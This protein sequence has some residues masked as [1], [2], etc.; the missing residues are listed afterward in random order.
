MRRPARCGSQHPP[1]RLVACKTPRRK[2]AELGSCLCRAHSGSNPALVLIEAKA[3]VQEFTNGAAGQPAN[4]NSENRER[5]GRAISEARDAL[6]R[7]ANEIGISR[8]SW[9]QF[10]NRVAFA[11]KL[12]S[13]GTPTALIYLGFTG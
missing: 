3:H 7:H 5:I 8:D 10:S 12:A 1:A 6:S 4:I 13:E 11:W 9:Y 2:R